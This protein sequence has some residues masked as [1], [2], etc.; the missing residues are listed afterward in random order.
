[1]GVG[2][3]VAV[4]PRKIDLVLKH[5]KKSG[6]RAWVIGQV[7]RKKTRCE[8]RVRDESGAEAVLVY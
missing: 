8:V 1:M 6:E 2:M 3:V 5:L 7:T 4:S